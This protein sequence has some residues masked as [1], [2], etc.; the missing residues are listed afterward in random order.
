MKVAQLFPSLCYPMDYTVHGILQDR[1]L[2]WV[3]F[4]FSR[5]IFPTRG[6][7][8]GLLHC[9]WILYQLNHHRSLQKRALINSQNIISW[10][11]SSRSGTGRLMTYSSCYGIPS[12]NSGDRKIRE[13]LHIFSRNFQIQFTLQDLSLNA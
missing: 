7:N 10:T 12:P 3:D 4:P 5:G 1:I 13:E 9:R 8:P 2:E 6:S 11:T